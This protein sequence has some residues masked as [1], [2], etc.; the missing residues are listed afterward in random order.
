MTCARIQN[1]DP[2]NTLAVY[3]GE[4]RTPSLLTAAEERSL[5]NAISG[6]D[7]DARSRMIQA[8]LRHGAGH[9]A[10][11]FDRRREHRFDTRNRGV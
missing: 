9:G 8:N 5:A 3:L 2:G 7:K 6:G 4:I 10:R 1:C 11:R